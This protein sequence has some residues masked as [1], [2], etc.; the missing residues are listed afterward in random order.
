M[1]VAGVRDPPIVAASCWAARD[2]L[3]LIYVSALI[4]MGFSPLV[5]LHR[6]GRRRTRP[7]RRVPRWLAILAIYLVVV[8]VVVFLGLLVIP[9]LVAQASS[10]GTAARQFNRLQTFLIRYKL[11]TRRDHARGSGVERADRHAAA[12][13]SAPCSSRSRASSAA[14]SR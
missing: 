11:M 9:P 2:A 7:P 5:T 6:D 3:L 13:P 10:L 8:G 12:T 4:A 14:S 1:T